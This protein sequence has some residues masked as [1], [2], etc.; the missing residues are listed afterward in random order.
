MDRR[1]QTAPIPESGGILF[2][3][4]ADDHVLQTLNVD[5]VGS[6]LAAE[7]ISQHAAG[8]GVLV[9]DGALPGGA[10]ED[11]HGPEAD[12]GLLALELIE[13]AIALGVEV[14]LEHVVGLVAK[15]TDQGEAVGALLAGAAKDE[16]GGVILFRKELEAGGVL[17]GVD[18]VL[19]GELL[20]QGLAQLEEIVQGILYD[21][22]AARTPEEEDGLGVLDGEGG[23]LCQGTLRAGVTRFSFFPDKKKLVSEGVS[24]VFILLPF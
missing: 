8:S 24:F 15:G 19:L 9:L 22:R 18:G 5:L 13:A 7:E 4:G 2:F 21:L 23:T 12:G 1:L 17:E 3:G 10:G 20:G 16:E 6:A 14:E 11:D